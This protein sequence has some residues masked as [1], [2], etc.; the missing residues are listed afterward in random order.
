MNTSDQAAVWI[1]RWLAAGVV[2][3]LLMVVIGGVTRLT[4]SGL[5]MV[6]WKPI[7]GV[8]PPLN[9]QDW[10]EAFHKYQQYP[11]FQQNHPTMT[12]G[13]FKGIYFWEY[14]HRLVG[15]LT[16]IVFLVPLGV[17]LF[18]NWLSR[19]VKRRVAWMFLLGLLQAFAGW[20]MVKS[21]LVDRPDVSHYRLALH[22]ILA[23]A[24]VTVIY[25]T[26]LDMRQVPRQGSHT[27]L[28]VWVR[29]LLGLV[30]L[31][32]IYGAFTAGL[33]GGI[34]YNTFPLMNGSWLPA[35][36]QALH[37][38]WKNWIEQPHMVQ[39]I[40]RTL[41][42]LNLCGILA[43]FFVSRDLAGPSLAGRLRLA[44]LIWAGAQFSLGVATLLL[45]V[46]VP[47]AAMH[48]LG[49]FLL[50]LLLITLEWSL[51]LAPGPKSELDTAQEE[52]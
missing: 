21:G 10:S 50:W 13:E 52:A 17:F 30:L 14:L 15:R 44:V 45:V 48:Q 29:S 47:V 33:D 41:G 7:L 9:R 11:E 36:S 8:V 34:G 3:V 28:S 42:W 26:W 20:F 25:R 39:F 43:F 40:H 27:S 51:R 19:L 35:G 37:P 16:G 18:R 2:L 31:Q 6:E 23:L 1:R 4:H 49:A 38:I 24:L 5:S 32:M 12:L 46:P 22:L